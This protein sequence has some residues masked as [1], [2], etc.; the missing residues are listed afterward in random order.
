MKLQRLSAA[1][2]ATMLMIIPVTVFAQTVPAAT[3]PELHAF[4]EVE[5]ARQATYMSLAG[6]HRQRVMAIAEAMKSGNVSYDTAAQEINR[7]LTP[8]E[9]QSVLEV[10]SSF[11]GALR[12][13]T[14][15]QSAALLVIPQ[16]DAGQFL[17]F[18]FDGI[19]T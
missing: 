15:S 4:F 2:A 3:S 7:V 14:R 12:G 11:W 17:L 16:I 5:Y 13:M 1:I 10:E 8:R 6:D 19:H 18:L 9:Q